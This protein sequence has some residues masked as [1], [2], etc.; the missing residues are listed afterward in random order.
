[1]APEKEMPLVVKGTPPRNPSKP[2]ETLSGT[3]PSLCLPS[4]SCG[5]QECPDG[6]PDGLYRPNGS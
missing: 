6:V 1:M 2:P 4:W 3:Y 5:G